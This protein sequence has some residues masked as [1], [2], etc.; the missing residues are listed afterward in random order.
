MAL[1]RSLEVSDDDS[2]K[3]RKVDEASMQMSRYLRQKGIQHLRGGAYRAKDLDKKFVTVLSVGPEACGRDLE[4]VQQRE[5]IFP[6]IFW[7]L[8]A[9]SL[10]VGPSVFKTDCETRALHYPFVYLYLMFL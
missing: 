4:A 7:D 2:Y 8:V 9:H 1:Q 10:L 5:V 3:N 6:K